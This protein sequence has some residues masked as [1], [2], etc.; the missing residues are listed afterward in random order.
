MTVAMHRAALIVNPKSGLSG[1]HTKP[2]EIASLL[3]DAG[4]E[5]STFVTTELQSAAVLARQAIR[6]GY[7]TVVAC[8]GDGTISQVASALAGTATALG[9]LPAGT[10][11]H[12]AKDMHIP[13]DLMEATQVVARRKTELIDIGEVNGKS[14]VNNSSLGIYPN[15]VTD[16]ERR[17]KMGLNKPIAFVLAILQ[18]LRRY[19]FLDVRIEAKGDCIAART[20]FVFIGNNEY[21]IRGLNIGTRKCLNAGRLY[22]YIAAPVSR[23]GLVRMGAAALLG[24]V[25]QTGSLQ[26]SSVEEAWIETRRRHVRLSNDGEMLRLHTP[27]HYV[28]RPRALRV[29]VP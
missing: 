17:R 3:T 23:W 19:P 14:F 24:R 13:L 5:N 10:L 4:I 18:V 16:R 21:E 2:T 12:F 26:M 15:I 6:E 9:V 8:G 11:N 1:R 25:D 29:I 27:L 7:E 28:L 20:P 22:L